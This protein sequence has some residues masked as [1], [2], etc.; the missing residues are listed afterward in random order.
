MNDPRTIAE[1]QVAVDGAEALLG[2]D[3][4]RQYGLVTGGPKC[5]AARCREILDRGAKIGVKP[6]SDCFE[7][8]V[9]ELNGPGP[10]GEAA[11]PARPSEESPS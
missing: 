6:E 3:A 8:L 7:R 11:R 5:N 2:L 10:A 1:W 4:A 9:A